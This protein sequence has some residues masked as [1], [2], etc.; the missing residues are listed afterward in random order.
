MCN[1]KKNDLTPK[2]ILKAWQISKF[3]IFRIS[4]TQFGNFT[5]SIYSIKAGLGVV[6]TNL[7]IEWNPVYKEF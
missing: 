1:F 7:H 3:L 5:K 4:T 2:Q 6:Q